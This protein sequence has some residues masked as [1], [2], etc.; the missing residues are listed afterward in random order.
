MSTPSS[1]ESL[2]KALRC[3]P[4][5]GPKSAQRMAYHLLQHDRSGASSL[6]DALQHA[7]GALR[8]CQRCNT[9]T[10][11]DICERCLSGKRDASLLCVVETPVDMNMMEQTHAYAGL[12]YVLIGRVSPLDGI[13]PR[14]LQ[15]DQLLARACDG[16]V[17][18]V[19]LAT[20][21][22][23]EGEVTAHYL[24]EMLRSRAIRVSRIARGVPVGGELEYVDAGTLA[25][26]VRERRSLT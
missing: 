22:T 20:N 23:N 18:E 7:L 17:Q 12:Y 19:I 9:F 13:G 25:Q 16:V 24:A 26:A 11:A 4:G 5:I 6:A 1:L 8:H 15:L 14:E 21:F 2:I 10:E 3:L